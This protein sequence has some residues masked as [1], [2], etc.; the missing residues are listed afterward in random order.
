MKKK[1]FLAA[2]LCIVGSQ[3]LAGCGDDAVR[4]EAK[5]DSTREKEVQEDIPQEDEVQGGTTQDTGEEANTNTD[6]VSDNPGDKNDSQADQ[7]YRVG[8]AIELVTDDGGSLELTVTDW[9]G[10]I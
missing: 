10:R 2:V 4:E 9:G 3:I 1:Y 8:D 5:E 6:V 7:G